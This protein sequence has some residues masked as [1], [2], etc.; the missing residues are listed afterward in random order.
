MALN[1][2]TFIADF[3]N[4]DSL[5]HFLSFLMGKFNIQEMERNIRN[6]QRA[7]RPR[8]NPCLLLVFYKSYFSRLF[9][10]RLRYCIQQFFAVFRRCTYI[11]VCYAMPVNDGCYEERSARYCYSAIILAYSSCIRQYP[12]TSYHL[13]LYTALLQVV[14]VWRSACTVC[15]SLNA[16]DCL[17]YSCYCCYYSN[18]R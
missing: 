10:T 9:N 12:V 3:V 7:S 4:Q 15:C 5:V 2:T 14:S 17:Y 6:R 1:F 8:G 16:I 18:F 11:S 13:A